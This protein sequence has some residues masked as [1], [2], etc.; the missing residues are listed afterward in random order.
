[1]CYC[2]LLASLHALSISACNSFVDLALACRR[3]R[4]FGPC[5]SVAHGRF[6][7]ARR[8]DTLARE[9]SRRAIG[10]DRP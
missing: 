10:H 6:Q 1:M 8:A 9:R 7:E 4:Q 3:Q 5:L 2:M